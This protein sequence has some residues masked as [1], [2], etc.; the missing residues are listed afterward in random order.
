MTLLEVL[1]KVSSEDLDELVHEAAAEAAALANNEGLE[2]QISF[3]KYYGWSDS[4]II[5][6]LGIEKGK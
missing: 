3:L 5:R 2:A 1:K 6:N 4:D